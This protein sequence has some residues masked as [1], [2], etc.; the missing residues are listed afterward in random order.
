MMLVC[1]DSVLHMYLFDLVHPIKVSNDLLSRVLLLETVELQQI[2][3]SCSMNLLFTQYS[4]HKDPKTKHLL[5]I[6]HTMF[7]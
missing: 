5:H 3:A 2:L 1:V 7:V 4:Q 6:Y